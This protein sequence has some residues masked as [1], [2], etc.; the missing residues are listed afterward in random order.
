MLQISE[1]YLKEL[2]YIKDIQAAR[3]NELEKYRNIFLRGKLT[4]TGKLH[5][6]AYNKSES[7]HRYL[8]DDNN[9]E[10]RRIKELRYLDVYLSRIE[11]NIK[12]TESFIERL[13]TTDYDSVN[14]VLPKTYRHPNIGSSV[15]EGKSKVW[16]KRAEALKGRYD[17]YRP[18]ELN[19]RT[20]DGTM[21]RSKSEALIYNYLLSVDATFIY[22]L[23]IKIDGRLLIPD[24][25][26]LS[27]IDNETE[28]LIE[29]QGLMNNEFYRNKFADKVYRYL[30]GDYVQG[31]NIFYTFD[32]IDGGF[33]M[34]PIECLIK[35]H[36]K[37]V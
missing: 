1:S 14:K 31:I 17:V 33:D 3:R 23:P 22:E 13:L 15:S 11:N 32:N 5:Y 26:I 2:N 29:H 7:G 6:C 9:E 18:E 21:V 19:K 25:T 28:I 8:G 30:R 10:V 36:V 35:S 27:D 24:F 16:K 34:T 4:P 12:E 37:R 20:N